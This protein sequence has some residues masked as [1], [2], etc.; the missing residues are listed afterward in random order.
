MARCGLA[1]S[2]PLAS[3]ALPLLTVVL[4]KNDPKSAAL[5]I[6]QALENKSIGMIVVGIPLLLSGKESRMTVWARELYQE[7]CSCLKEDSINVTTWDERLSSRQADVLL[8]ESQLKKKRRKEV[9]DSV[10]ATL[11]LQSYLDAM[12]NQKQ[13][14]SLRG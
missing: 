4:K 11:I 10:A 7:I 6:L 5:Q 3:F 9:Q 1:I 12:S 14:L 2:D 13:M 8:E